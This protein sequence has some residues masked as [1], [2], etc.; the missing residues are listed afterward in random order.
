[1]DSV[2]SANDELIA[3]DPIIKCY[4]LWHNET[5]INLEKKPARS[6]RVHHRIKF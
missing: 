5:G 6:S 3:S 4:I 2:G 1:M